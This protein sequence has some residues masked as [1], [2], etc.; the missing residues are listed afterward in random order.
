MQNQRCGSTERW[1]KREK[2]SQT[3][4]GRESSQTDETDSQEIHF[5][6]LGRESK[7]RHLDKQTLTNKYIH[8]V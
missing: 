2:E 3:K 4:I 6:K 7:K 1:G 8:L 5:Y